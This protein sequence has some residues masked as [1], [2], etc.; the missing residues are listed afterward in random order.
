MIDLAAELRA[1]GLSPEAIEVLAER[2]AE[3]A[4]RRVLDERERDALL[5]AKHAAA[6]LGLS[7]AAF[8]MRR[9]RDA[10]LD[11]LGAGAGRFRRWRRVD[12]E[13][14][15]RDKGRRSGAMLRALDGGRP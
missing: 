7:P 10:S 9:R 1:A 13:T 4:V 8:K 15:V 14:W 12:L 11:A 3:R 5:D 6:F 2:A